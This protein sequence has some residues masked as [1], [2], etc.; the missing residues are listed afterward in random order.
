MGNVDKTRLLLLSRHAPTQSARENAET[1]L[2][3]LE[4]T[5]KQQDTLLIE[6]ALLSEEAQ[7]LKHGYEYADAE[8]IFMDVQLKFPKSSKAHKK[9][10]FTHVLEQRMG[11]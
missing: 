11:A 4:E 9:A 5:V 8:E 6:K 7:P 3:A 2:K 10:L 1:V